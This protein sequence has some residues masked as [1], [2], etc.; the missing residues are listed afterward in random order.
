MR[1]KKNKGLTD[2]KEEIKAIDKVSFQ[3]VKDPDAGPKLADMLINGVPLVINFEFLAIDDSN[4]IIAFLAGVLYS[5]NGEVREI[6]PLVYM[7][8]R[9]IEF[10][11]GSLNDFLAQFKDND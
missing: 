11:D 8:A 9:K 7:F 3:E 10:M 5:I 1:K 2:E 4:K 6:K